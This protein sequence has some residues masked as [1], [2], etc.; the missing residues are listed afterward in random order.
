MR[1][2]PPRPPPRGGRGLS[3]SDSGGFAP[4]APQKARLWLP[5]G[6]LPSVPPLRGGSAVAFG[7]LSE[8]SKSDC[9]WF[10]L[11]RREMVFPPV[12]PCGGVFAPAPPSRTELGRYGCSQNRSTDFAASWASSRHNP[13]CATR[14]RTIVGDLGSTQFTPRLSIGYAAFGGYVRPAGRIG[15]EYVPPLPPRW[16]GIAPNPRPLPPGEGEEK[17]IPPRPPV[18]GFHASRGAVCRLRRRLFTP[19]GATS[20]VIPPPLDGAPSGDI[21]YLVCRTLI[22]CSSEVALLWLGVLPVD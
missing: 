11:L 9:F 3:P 18:G 14:R 21:P 7:G 6:P 8:A 5:S 20:I 15:G 13:V 10:H 19:G 12:P 17:R 4:R 16:G 2:I 22:R 1:G